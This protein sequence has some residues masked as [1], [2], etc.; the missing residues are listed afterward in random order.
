MPSKFYFNPQGNGA[1][2]FLGP[3]ESLLMEIAWKK[4]EISVK[5]AMIFLGD[6]N[7]LAYTTVMTVLNRLYEKKLLERERSGRNF[8][9]RPAMDRNSFLK[10]KI[11]IVKN[12]LKNIK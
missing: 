12:S 6:N 9:Y 5:K 11:D 8:I 2:V 3:T 7:K 1:D 4:K 10:N